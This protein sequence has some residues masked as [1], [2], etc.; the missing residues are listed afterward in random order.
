[1]I[2]FDA[3]RWNIFIYVAVIFIVN[4]FIF[5]D[6]ESLSADAFISFLSFHYFLVEDVASDLADY[7]SII[8][9]ILGAHCLMSHFRGCRSALWPF[10]LWLS[11]IF[12]TDFF[13]FIDISI[14]IFSVYISSDVDAFIIFISFDDIL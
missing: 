3:F 10:S 11:I 14:N 2:I 8:S 12:I 6:A 5:D 13:I 7:A 1:M 4:I 9:A